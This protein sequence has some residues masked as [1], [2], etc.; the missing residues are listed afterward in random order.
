MERLK[1]VNALKST[2]LGSEFLMFTI[3][4]RSQNAALTRDGQKFFAQ[5][6]FTISS[7]K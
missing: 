2:F 4:Q 6:A 1:L 5:L 7:K 3:R